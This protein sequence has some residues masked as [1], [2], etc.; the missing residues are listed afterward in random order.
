MFTTRTVPYKNVLNRDSPSERL[1]NTV[2]VSGHYDRMKYFY[3]KIAALNQTVQVIL[4]KS[5]PNEQ[6]IIYGR[7]LIKPKIRIP[8]NHHS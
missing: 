4:K 3:M 7:T 1:R 6:L 5:G 2:L 8:L